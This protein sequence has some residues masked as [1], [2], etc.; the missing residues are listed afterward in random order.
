MPK[1][2]NVNNKK[3]EVFENLEIITLLNE[4]FFVPKKYPI[5]KNK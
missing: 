3:K 5:I 4:D 2:P 1:I